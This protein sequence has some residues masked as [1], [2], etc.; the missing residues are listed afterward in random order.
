MRGN[1]RSNTKPE[2]ALRS[3]LHRRGFRFRKDHRLDL[4]GLKVR[5]DVVFPR[6]K[7]AVFV[8]GCFWHSCP[9]HRGTTPKTNADYWGPKLARVVERDRQQDEA[10]EEAGWIVVRV[11]EHVP[12]LEAAD[13]I[14]KIIIRRQA[15][16]T[17][18]GEALP[19][20]GLRD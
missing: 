14:S 12:P 18:R 5:P 13:I 19:S 7:V 15:S 8:D 6:V 3:E 10:L 1:K 16:E 11:W 4:G 9:E 20:I 2:L 17:S